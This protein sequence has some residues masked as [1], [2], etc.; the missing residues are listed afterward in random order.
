MNGKILAAA[1]GAAMLLSLSGC[2][3]GEK[4]NVTDRSVKTASND[5]PVLTE[6]N[7]NPISTKAEDN[8]VS[9]EAEADSEINVNAEDFIYTENENGEIIITGYKGKENKA[10]FPNEI[11][12]KRVVQIGNDSSDDSVVGN[13]VQSVY[14]PEGI[15]KIGGWAFASCEN[16]RYVTLGEDVEKIDSAAFERCKRLEKIIIPDSVKYIGSSAFAESGLKEINIPAGVDIIYSGAFED[17]KNLEKVTFAEGTERIMDF[18]FQGCDKLKSVAL[19]DSV[20]DIDL[21][22]FENCEVTFKGVTY[23]PAKYYEELYEAV[24]GHPYQMPSG[25][26]PAA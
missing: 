13:D 2:G 18:T 11:E 15:V 4:I 17:C 6:A 10:V 23:P 8:P 7:D 24:N 22:V 9:I 21:M 20:N 5:N 19:P 1:L 16:L 3:S 26:P 25:I 14:V 12:G